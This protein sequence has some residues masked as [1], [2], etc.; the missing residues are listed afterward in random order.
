MV[1]NKIS[2]VIGG[3]DENVD[4]RA[5]LELLVEAIALLGDIEAQQLGARARLRWTFTSASKNSPLRLEILG[6]TPHERGS[7]IPVAKL[8]LEG[9]D[10]LEN[11]GPIPSW[12]DAEM[13]GRA[14]RIV[15][16]IG[17]EISSLTFGSPERIVRVTQRVA[18]NAD[19]FRLPE[20]YSEFSEHE[21]V[22]GQITAHEQAR[23]FC[24]FDPITNRKIHCVFP[25]EDLGRV[26]DALT[27]RVFVSGL[28]TYR[29]KDDLPLSIQVDDWSVLRSD[30]E[31]PSLDEIH[32]MGVDLTKG[33][34]SEDVIADLRRLDA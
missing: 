33:R 17:T 34:R 21:G 28:T 25:I 1:E 26:R 7:A 32:A 20:K 16:R 27:R 10:A 24:I 19:L 12:L 3:K 30:S 9:M 8:F 2:I 4:A 22:L 6:I 29:R 14:K 11:S 18:A 5:S 13:M 23:E 15:R 31:L